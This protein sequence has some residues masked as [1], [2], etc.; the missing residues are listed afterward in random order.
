MKY[1]SPSIYHSNVIAKIKVFKKVDQTPKSRSQGKTFWYP[2][3]GLVTR[4]SHVKYQNLSICHSK[5]I[6]KVKSFNK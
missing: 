3:K 2:L 6:A 5:G 1:Q 4:N